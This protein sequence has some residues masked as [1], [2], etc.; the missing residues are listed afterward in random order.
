M[1]KEKAAF[2]KWKETLRGI[3]GDP[4]LALAMM[5]ARDDVRKQFFQPGIETRRNLK[6]ARQKVQ[7][8][9]RGTVVSM[10]ASLRYFKT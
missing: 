9:N 3:G 10:R 5:K 4:K 2:R 8:R 7:M 6:A 1:L